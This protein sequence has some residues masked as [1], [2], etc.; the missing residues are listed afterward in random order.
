MSRHEQADMKL[1]LVTFVGTVA[2]NIVT[3][4]VVAV[5]VISVRP[6]TGGHPTVVGVLMDLFCVTAGVVVVS[7]GLAVF[8]GNKRSS[9]TIC[10]V[11]VAVIGSVAVSM[12][13]I[14]LVF[15][16]VLLGYAVGVR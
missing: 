6:T 4:L 9:D 15:L 7:S 11:V 14:G 13:L 2:A 12:G 10:R 1:F 8:R 3:V 16:L 5:A